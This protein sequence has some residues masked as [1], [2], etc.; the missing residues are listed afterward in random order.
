MSITLVGRFTH[1]SAFPKGDSGANTY[2]IMVG[3]IWTKNA[4]AR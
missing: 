3:V 1:D 2:G 4:N